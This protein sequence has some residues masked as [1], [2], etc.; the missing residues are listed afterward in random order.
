MN[1]WKEFEKQCTAYLNQK[2]G[3]YA[4][5]THQGG[6]DSTVPDI[7][8]ET[9][10]GNAFYIDAKHTPAQC[11]QFVLIPDFQS[12]TFLYSPKNASAVNVY[13]KA[14]MDYMN[15][16]F[17]MFAQ[18]GTTGKEIAMPNGTSIFSNWIVQM[19]QEKGVQFFIT[20]ENTIF[21]ISQIADYF[22]ITAKYRI[23]RSG[24]GSVGKTR[25]EKVAAYIKS[26]YYEITSVH[27]DKNK[28]FVTALQELHNERFECDGNEYMFSKR[29]NVYEIRRLSNT[30]H[31]NVIFSITN[32]SGV[33]GMCDDDFIRCL[34]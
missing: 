14:I 21:P 16:D 11:G 17:R 30:F 19:Y 34:V 29:G 10:S 23:K 1:T 32:K 4:R 7:F 20:N 2:F 24:S 18:A 25:I 9:R 8:V 33:Q 13:A 28:L 6:S 3:T 31:A 5:F 27:S 22:Y 12:E 26:N 15:Q